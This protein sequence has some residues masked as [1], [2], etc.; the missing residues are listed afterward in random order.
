MISCSL[1][2]MGGSQEDRLFRGLGGVLKS[3]LHRV[4]AIELHDQIAVPSVCSRRVVSAAISRKSASWIEADTVNARISA[5]LTLQ[6]A[7]DVD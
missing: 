1:P 6:A 2:R 4:G 5:L 7:R 3:G